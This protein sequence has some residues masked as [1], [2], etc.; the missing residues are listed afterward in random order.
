MALLLVPL[1]SL[2]SLP[3]TA[4]TLRWSSQGDAATHDP[5]AQ[6]EGVNNQINGQIYEQLLTRDKSLKPQ[7]CLA[8]AWKQVS[9]TVWVFNLRKGVKWQDGSP[10]TADDVVFSVL[11]A[12]QDTSNMKV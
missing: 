1:L 2:L 11:R 3:A 9:P 12:Q 8:V 7:P 4:K 6:N 5:H 10:F